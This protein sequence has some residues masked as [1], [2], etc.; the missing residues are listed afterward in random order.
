MEVSEET[1]NSDVTKDKNIDGAVIVKTDLKLTHL[2]LSRLDLRKQIDAIEE[3]VGGI[4][5]AL[6]IQKYNKA[7]QEIAQ[8]AVW[9]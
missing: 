6:C 2:I 3:Q 1:S 7:T 8:S 9:L 4:L 5:L